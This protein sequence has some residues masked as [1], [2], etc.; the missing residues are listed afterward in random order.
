MGIDGV[1]A[2]LTLVDASQDKVLQA[3]AGFDA[4]HDKMSLEQWQQVI[5]VNLTGVFNCLQLVGRDMKRRAEAGERQ[6]GA[7]VNI[8]S[9]AGRKGT[10]G[11]VN[12]GAAKAGVLGITMSA[13]REWGRYGVRVNS[14]SF[15]VV[16]TEMTEVIRGEKFRDK[17]LESIPLKRFVDPEEAVRPIAFM[18][19]E[20]AAYVTGQHL[21]VNGGAHMAGRKKDWS[22]RQESNLYL[23]LRRHS[24]Y[25]LNYEERTGADCRAPPCGPRVSGAGSRAVRWPVAGLREH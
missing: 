18:L 12:Y 15:G 4:S 19:S 16:A 7:I 22:P 13:A 6:S 8:S 25:P 10:I 2:L 20:A 1:A 17:L 3:A 24:F 11:Q 14:I 9:D 5:D 21:S 23:A